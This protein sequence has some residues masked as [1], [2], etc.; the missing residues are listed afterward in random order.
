MRLLIVRL[1]SMGDV[2]HALPAVAAVRSAVPDAYIGWAIERR[3]TPLL[4]SG[5]PTLTGVGRVGNQETGNRSPQRPLVDRVLVV[6][7]LA[8]RKSPFSDATWSDVRN[9]FRDL[10]AQH[11]D[12]AI[13]FQGSMKSALVAQFS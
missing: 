10:R 3:W 13:D 8:W 1:G 4:E 7:T 12:L 11:Y 2:L 5:C 6:N 9:T